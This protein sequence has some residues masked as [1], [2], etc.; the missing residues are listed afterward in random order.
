ML[1]WFLYWYAFRIDTKTC[2]SKGDY[3][4]LVL[5]WHDYE[6]LNGFL[7]I[8]STNCR[9]SLSCIWGSSTTK[10]DKVASFNQRNEILKFKD[11]FLKRMK[12]CCHLLWI[13]RVWFY[14]LSLTA[15]TLLPGWFYRFNQ[16]N[17]A[18]YKRHFSRVVVVMTEPTWAFH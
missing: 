12:I 15:R 5:N 10:A 11:Y 2:W 13:W 8:M 16:K 14:G 17:S 18:N 9:L 3:E 7:K 1:K 6:N 4:T